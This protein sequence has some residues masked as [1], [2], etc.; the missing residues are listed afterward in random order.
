[1]L[2]V[3]ETP[4]DLFS[5]EGS[6]SF[7]GL[8][9][10]LHG[11]LAPIEGIGPDELK[12]QELLDRVKSSDIKEVILA[13]N[14][15]IEGEATATYIADLLRKYVSK[16]TKPALGLPSGAH[17]EYADARTLLVSMNKRDSI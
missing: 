14:P 12:I 16:I 15:N 10:V 17:L 4:Q 3:V 9:H 2:C 8:Y 1:V 13:T 7:N 5:L 11:H 6:K